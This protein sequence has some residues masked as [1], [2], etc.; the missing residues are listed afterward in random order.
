MALENFCHNCG[1]RVLPNEP[2]CTQCGCKTGH[3]D[4][5]DLIVLIPP[6]H[7]IGFFNFSI[8]FS[9][10]IE[11]D[12][13]DFKYEICSCGY[14]NDV[15]NEYCYMCGAKRSQSRLSRILKHKPKPKFEIG[16][17]LCE[18]GNVNP[19]ENLFCDMCGRQLREVPFQNKDNFSNFNLEFKDSIFCFCGEENEKFSQFCKNCGRPLKNYGPSSSISILCTCSTINE[20]TS[21]FCVGCGKSLNKEDS[22]LICVCGHKNKRGLKFCETC[23]RPLNP[24]KIIKTKI[25]CSCGEIL[26]WDAD[27]CHNCGKNIK[28][29]IDYSNSIHKTVKNIKSVLR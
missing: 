13:I 25:I 23:D 18:C 28:R 26:D 12:N 8:D 24:Q 11:R 3:V 9:P 6:I 5:G 22:L 4:N 1:H 19:K 21:D 2:F 14:L 15:N 7:D 10:Y 29:S 20:V 16:N 27:F 17:V